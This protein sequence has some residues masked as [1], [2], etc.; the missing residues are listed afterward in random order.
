MR[1][2]ISRLKFKWLLPALIA[3]ATLAIVACGGEAA[4]TI[5]ETVI[6]EKQIPGERVVE[7]VIVTIKGDTIVVT[8]TPG[9]ASDVAPPGAPSGT[10]TVA[11]PAVFSFVGIPSANGGRQGERL[12]WLGIHETANRMNA[13]AQIVPHLAESWVISTDGLRQT[14]KFRQGIQ[15][16]G[17]WGEMTS[18]DWKWTADDQWQGKPTSNHGGQF[19]ATTYLDETRIIDKYTI[20]FV[21]NTPNSFFKE[22]YGSIRDDVALAVYSKN[23]VDTLGVEAAKTE[24]PDGG[25]GPYMVDKWISDNE[26][27]I[28]AFPDYWGDQPEYETIKI[29]QISEPSTVLA[30]LAT[31]EIDASKVAVTQRSRVEADGL[32]V[33]SAGLGFASFTVSGQFCFTE[34]LGETIPTR[35]GYDPTLPWVGDCNDPASLETAKQVRL[36]LSMAIDRQALVDVIAGGEGRPSYVQ[37]LQ[38]FFADRYMQPDWVVPFDPE[39][40]MK[41]ISDA[42]YP[43]GFDFQLVCSSAGH[44]LLNEFCDSVAGMWDAIGLTPKIQRI[45]DDALR[46]Q[47]VDRSFNGIRIGVGTGVTP[48]PEARGFGEN[49]LSAY[50]SGYEV[51]GLLVHVAAAALATTPAQLDLI[52]NRQYAWAFDQQLNVPLIEFNEIYAV[53]SDKIGEW[54]R[55]PFNGH[56]SELMDFEHLQKPR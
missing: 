50:N 46:V 52:R 38:G 9:P 28:K 36:A 55:T 48:I 15:F 56:A 3:G 42:G 41:I 37:M 4:T 51:P 6:V 26:I 10:L 32:E 54:P 21:L 29:V 7:T 17:G 25:T 22:Y 16:H 49:P 45:A 20:E 35:P 47:L 19:I 39:G 14:V 30:A 1:F 2:E 33:R 40:A 34:Y 13:A 53:N 11:W 27:V 44:P 5:V 8:A 43:N 24:L 23:R 31:G 12:V 18:A